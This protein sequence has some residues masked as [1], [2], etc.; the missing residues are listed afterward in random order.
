MKKLPNWIIVLIAIPKKAITFFFHSPRHVANHIFGEEHSIEHRF[1]AG[2]IVSLTA[3]VV[4]LSGGIVH[5]HVVEKGIEFLATS[6]HATGFYSVLEYANT[7]AK[8]K[9]QDEESFE[10]CVNCK[11]L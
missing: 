9:K 7:K 3:F 2:A 4:S 8:K 11:P 10:T 6:I 5:A 1:L